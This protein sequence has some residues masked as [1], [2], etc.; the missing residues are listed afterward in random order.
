MPPPYDRGAATGCQVAILGLVLHIGLVSQS[1]LPFYT[2]FSTKAQIINVRVIGLKGATG[3]SIAGNSLRGLKGA[4]SRLEQSVLGGRLV[5][6]VAD[7]GMPSGL[8]LGGIIVVLGVFDPPSSQ[9][10]LLVVLEELV[11]GAIGA[12]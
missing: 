2:N 11:A 1:S 7:P 4:G 5:D 9:R 6:G 10:Q 3:L 8:D 12:N